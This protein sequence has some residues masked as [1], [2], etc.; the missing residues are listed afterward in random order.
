M[1]VPQ[2]HVRKEDILPLCIENLLHHSSIEDNA[3][4]ENINI[5]CCQMSA[6][7]TVA[8]TRRKHK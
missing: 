5:L 7:F 3:K 8:Y 4:G 2:G 6:Y 1:E